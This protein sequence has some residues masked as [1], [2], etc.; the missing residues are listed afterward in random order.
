MFSGC[1]KKDSLKNELPTP[2]NKS[3]N[4]YPENILKIV[5][6]IIGNKMKYPDS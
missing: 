6:Y 4:K 5:K 1:T 3:L 2:K